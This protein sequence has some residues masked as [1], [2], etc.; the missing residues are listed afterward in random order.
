M[1]GREGKGE[2]KVCW[3]RGQGRRR[4]GVGRRRATRGGKES[5]K[6]TGTRGEGRESKW[7]AIL[8]KHV[9]A[10]K[11]CACA[12]ASSVCAPPHGCCSVR[13]ARRHSRC[14]A[15]SHFA[16]TPFVLARY[17]VAS[18]L[19]AASFDSAAAALESAAAARETA[20]ARSAFSLRAVWCGCGGAHGIEGSA[21]TNEQSVLSSMGCVCRV[22]LQLV[23]WL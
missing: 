6:T 23:G 11:A 3:R 9:R 7:G 22:G 4:E 8:S 14:G 18:A 15:C 10:L 2:G 21:E 13:W 19:A 20:L 5:P 16:I 1:S 17:R 12:Q